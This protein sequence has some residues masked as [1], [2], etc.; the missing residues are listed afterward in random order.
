ME[1]IVLAGGFGTRLSS[2]LADVPK[3]MAPIAGRPFLEILLDSLARKGFYRVILSLGFMARTISDHFKTQFAGM[4]IACVVENTPLGTGGAIRLALES[5]THDHVFVFNGDSYLDLD[6]QSLEHQWLTRRRP[7]VVCR[8]VSNTARYGKIVVASQSIISFVEKGTIGPGL[9]NAGCYVM[10]SDALINFPPDLPFSIE[11]GYFVPEVAR[12][13]VD[14]FE[15]TG[16]FIDIGTPEDYAR[17]QI[18]LTDL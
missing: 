7:I 10:A 3:P 15:T 18:L 16:L 11:T 17:A 13:G 5:C 14:V 2:V 9:I 6:V 1:A 8:H 12:I 4:E